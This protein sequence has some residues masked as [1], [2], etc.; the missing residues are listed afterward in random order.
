MPRTAASPTARPLLAELSVINEGSGDT[1][2][3]QA[4]VPYATRAAIMMGMQFAQSDL[5]LT[6]LYWDVMEPAEGHQVVIG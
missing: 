4:R 1:E 6:V 3:L 5:L 2:H